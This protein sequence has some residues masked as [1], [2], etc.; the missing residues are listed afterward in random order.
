MTRGII[1]L[2]FRCSGVLTAT[3]EV[4]AFRW[5]DR[6]QIAELADKASPSASSTPC[7]PTAR[8]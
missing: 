8:Q 5:A 6:S 2:V 1:A 7:A 4:S 3:N